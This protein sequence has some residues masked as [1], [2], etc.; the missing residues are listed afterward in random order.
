MNGLRLKF[1]TYGFY[2]VVAFSDIAENTPLFTYFDALSIFGAKGKYTNHHNHHRLRT[3]ES[4]SHQ[5]SAPRQLN[6]QLP[7]FT[8]AFR[9]DLGSSYYLA[10][11]VIS[12]LAHQQVSRPS[13][14]LS[15]SNTIL[16]PSTESSFETNIL[17][18]RNTQHFAPCR[19][20][21]IELDINIM[22]ASSS[23][24][25]QCRPLYFYRHLSECF[26]VSS[27]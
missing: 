4:I 17:P 21:K 15:T 11:A 22:D 26:S 7:A 6:L 25:F 24:L 5:C 14:N 8:S 18:Q 20:Q 13:R 2:L 9:L 16:A 3:V 23:Y 1:M 12:H 10:L 19:N 27:S